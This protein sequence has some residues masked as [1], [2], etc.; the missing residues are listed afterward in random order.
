MQCD[1]YIKMNTAKVNQCR[2]IRKTTILKQK[3]IQ[4]KIDMY[5]TNVISRAEFV[6]MVSYKL[7]SVNKI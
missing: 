2:P 1:T 5:D 3:F 6:R 4:N 7:S